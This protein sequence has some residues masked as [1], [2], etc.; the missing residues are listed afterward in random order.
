MKNEYKV[1]IA[2]IVVIL[3]VLVGA[4]ALGG[5]NGPSMVS[6]TATPTPQP[7]PEPT[8]MPT[9]VPSATVDATSATPAPT[10]TGNGD[11]IQTEYGYVVTKATLGPQNWTNPTPKPTLPTPVLVSPANGT[12]FNNVPAPRTPTLTWLSVPGATKYRVE[13]QWC[14]R[15]PDWLSY[16]AVEVTSTSYTFSTTHPQCRWRVTALDGSGGSSLPSD[17]WIFMYVSS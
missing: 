14:D 5:F 7:T 15:S 13:C 12:R 8:P 2:A 11:I 10:P 9:A 17:W 3:I 6:P 16:P 1:L 4:Y